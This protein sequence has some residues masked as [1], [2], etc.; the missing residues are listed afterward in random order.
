MADNG[1]VLA[2]VGHLEYSS[3]TFAQMPNSPPISVRCLPQNNILKKLLYRRSTKSH[4]V[5]IIAVA[6]KLIRIAFALVK[7]NTE[8]KPILLETK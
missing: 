1:Y 4:K 8:Y 7:N 6:H 5:A 3:P 2:M